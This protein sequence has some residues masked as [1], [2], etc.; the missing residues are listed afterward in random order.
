MM[1]SRFGAAKYLS[2]VV[3]DDP[4]CARPTLAASGP[5]G[6][7]RGLPCLLTIDYLVQMSRLLCWPVLATTAV[8][9]MGFP[10]APPGAR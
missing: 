2:G 6:D 1:A 3:G 10:L 8:E 5:P 9:P 4:A 7:S